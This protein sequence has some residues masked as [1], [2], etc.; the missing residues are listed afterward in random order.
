MQSPESFLK[1]ALSRIGSPYAPFRIP[2]F[3][4]L[5]SRAFSQL[6]GN[7]TGFLRLLVSSRL[8]K[9]VTFGLQALNYP[10]FISDVAIL[11]AVDWF[12]GMLRTALNIWGDATAVVIVDNWADRY[13]KKHD[14]L[15]VTTANT[16]SSIQLPQKKDKELPESGIH[17]HGV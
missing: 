3:L 2:C 14:K 7:T 12:L 8:T 6:E 4:S 9:S 16:S 1:N 17:A 5:L 11:Y 13:A 15:P 10:Q